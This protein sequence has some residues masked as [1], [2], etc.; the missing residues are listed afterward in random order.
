MALIQFEEIQAFLPFLSGI[1]VTLSWRGRV[2]VCRAC[3]YFQDRKL[4]RVY[5]CVCGGGGVWA[6]EGS[7]CVC[8][9]NL[10]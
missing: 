8:V 3:S 4:P 5:V 2:L 9:Q 6:A 10:L 7:T 1:T